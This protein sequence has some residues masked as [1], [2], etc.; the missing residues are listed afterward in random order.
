M[1]NKIT[2]LVTPEFTKATNLTLEDLRK[3]E[4]T[5]KLKKKINNQKYYRR[6]KMLK[7]AAK[8]AQD[9]E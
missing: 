9:T 1:D 7:M 8:K 6:R 4:L 5:K 3:Y 2:I